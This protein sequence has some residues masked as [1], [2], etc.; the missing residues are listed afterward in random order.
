MIQCPETYRFKFIFNISSLYLKKFFFK[1][2]VGIDL[3]NHEMITTAVIL[4]SSMGKKFGSN[5]FSEKLIY[6][7]N[8]ANDLEH[9]SNIAKKFGL[10]NKENTKVEN[11]IIKNNVDF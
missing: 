5:Y 8:D 1:S 7:N 6:K 11:M 4:D 10:N 9:L 2:V 3:A